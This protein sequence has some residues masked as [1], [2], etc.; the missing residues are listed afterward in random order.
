MINY[1]SMCNDV[2][3]ES[4]KKRFTVKDMSFMRRDILE[5]LVE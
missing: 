1:G 5:G 2:L 3:T 4:Q